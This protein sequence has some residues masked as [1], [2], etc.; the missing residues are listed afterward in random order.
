MICGCCGVGGYG[1]GGVAWV[2]RCVMVDGGLEGAGD[3]ASGKSVDIS[4]GVRIWSGRLGDWEGD[5]IDG[6]GSGDSVGCFVC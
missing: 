1:G 3:L 6:E 4:C 5:C 2:K